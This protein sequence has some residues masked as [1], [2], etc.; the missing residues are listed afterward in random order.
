MNN[1]SLVLVASLLCL[2]L[3]AGAQSFDRQISDAAK[4]AIDSAKAA[5]KAGAAAQ[6]RFAAQGAP[7]EYAKSIV[8]TPP[9]ESG[10]PSRLVFAV[11]GSKVKDENAS[12][13]NDYR[14]SGFSNGKWTYSATSCDTQDYWFDFDAE[15]LLKTTAGQATAPVKGHARIETRG[16]TD[17]DGA[18]DCTARF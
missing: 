3:T 9:K 12:A 14:S 18:L 17:W 13:L 1:R 5:R 6:A 11:A 8:C 10:L 16:Q 15:S 7:K 2:G 4:A